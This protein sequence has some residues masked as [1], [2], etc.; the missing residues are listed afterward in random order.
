MVVPSANNILI[1]LCGR[2]GHSDFPT[3]VNVQAHL[4]NN[5]K[6]GN[7]L[8][9]GFFIERVGRKN[10]SVA[11][12]NLGRTKTPHAICVSRLSTEWAGSVNV[13]LFFIGGVGVRK[14]MF[15]LRAY[16]PYS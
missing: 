8:A 6:A 2:H 13:E 14:M 5:T 3:T 15:I 12:Q 11:R 10:F 9:T 16:M 4:D 1:Y 7:H